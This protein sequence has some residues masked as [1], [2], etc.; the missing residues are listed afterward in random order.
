M[1]AI[2]RPPSRAIRYAYGGKRWTDK[3]KQRLTKRAIVSTVPWQAFQ[4]LHMIT[5][6]AFSAPSPDEI[7]LPVDAQGWHL[8]L[9]IGLLTAPM[10]GCTPTV[11]YFV[12]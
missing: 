1:F 12:V 2:C 4:I 6:G 8:G 11:G 10:V 3:S 9:L 7:L 5:D